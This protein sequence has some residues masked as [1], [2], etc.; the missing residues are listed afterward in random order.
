MH[1]LTLPSTGMLFMG[2]ILAKLDD[3]LGVNCD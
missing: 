3:L 2:M 1:C